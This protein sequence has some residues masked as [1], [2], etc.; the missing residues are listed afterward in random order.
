MGCDISKWSSYHANHVPCAKSNGWSFLLAHLDHRLT[1]FSRFGRKLNLRNLPCNISV[2]HVS[3]WR[4]PDRFRNLLFIS[5]LFLYLLFDLRYHCYYQHGMRRGRMIW[6]ALMTFSIVGISS[7]QICKG[8]QHLDLYGLQ[9]SWGQGTAKS[10]RSQ[11]QHRSEIF[12]QSFIQ[13]VR[14]F[15]L[16]TDVAVGRTL[17]QQIQ[18]ADLSRLP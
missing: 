8:S 2:G 3:R 6:P 1:I 13:I 14:A 15:P 11:D 12:N 5:N 7:A 18:K 9:S 4:L 10:M 17:K 16:A